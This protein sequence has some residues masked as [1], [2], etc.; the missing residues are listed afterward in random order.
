MPL[1][2]ADVGL[3]FSLL[4]HV[5]GGLADEHTS[6]IDDCLIDMLRKRRDTLT[7][8]VAAVSA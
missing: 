7:V 4:G 6:V 5:E 3:Y 1:A 2:L 8:S